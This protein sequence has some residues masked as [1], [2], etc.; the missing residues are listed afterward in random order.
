MQKIL[1]ILQKHRTLLALGTLLFI[2]SCAV[3]CCN[4]Q[5]NRSESIG[6][7]LPRE[8]FVKLEKRIHVTVCPSESVKLTQCLDKK[9]G[10]SASGFI[11]K[12]DDEGSYVITAAHVCDDS[13][14]KA[15]LRAVKGAELVNKTFRILNID[16]EKFNF[17]TLKYDVDIDVCVGYVYGLAKPAVE[18]SKN[19]PI[20]GD[21]IYNLAAPIGIF[22]EQAIPILNGHYIGESNNM[23]QYSVPATG[24]SSGSPLLNSDGELVGLI[25][26][27]FVRFPFITLSPTYKQLI[28]FIYTHSNKDIY[29]IEKLFKKSLDL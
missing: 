17:I 5:K 1:D 15:F 13:E 7:I 27:V 19:G 9:M 3:Y 25:H 6:H 14:L 16:N 11:F 29:L 10:S 8:S 2:S 24:G 28:S 26:S 18:V 22:N 12:N 4:T 23:A 20:P 21:V